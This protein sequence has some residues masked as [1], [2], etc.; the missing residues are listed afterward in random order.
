[1]TAIAAPID[2]RIVRRRSMPTHSTRQV[3]LR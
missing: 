2:T 1:V 3:P